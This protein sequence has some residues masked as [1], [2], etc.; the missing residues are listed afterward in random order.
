MT[1]S[2]IIPVYNVAPYLRECLDSVCVAADRAGNREGGTGN[3]CGVE[4]ICV[5]DGS[6]DGN[7]EMLDE[8]ARRSTPTPSTH[9]FKVIHQPNVGVSAAR[10]RGLEI[11]TWEWVWFVDADDEIAEDSLKLL[12]GFIDD[13]RYAPLQWVSFRHDIIGESRVKPLKCDGVLYSKTADCRIAKTFF[14]VAWSRIFR[15]STIGSL[16]FRAYHYNEDA[17]FAMDFGSRGRGWLGVDA[18]LY[19]YRLSAGGGDVEKTVQGGRRK[20]L[21]ERE[22]PDRLR[23]P[24]RRKIP[25][26]GSVGVAS[27]SGYAQFPDVREGLFQAERGRTRRIAP[28]LAVPSGQVFGML[29]VLLQKK[30]LPLIGAAFP[31][32][33]GRQISCDRPRTGQWDLQTPLPEECV[34]N[35]LYICQNNLRDTSFG[36]VQ[37]THFISKA[38]K[39]CGTV[40]AFC[41]L[42]GKVTAVEDAALKYVIAGKVAPADCVCHWSA[43]PGVEIFG[44]VEDLDSLYEESLA[45]V[46]PVFSGSGT[47]IKV[48]ETGLRGRTVFAAPFAARGMAADAPFLKV[49]DTV[50]L[51]RRDLLAFL[52]RVQT[53]GEGRCPAAGDPARIRKDFEAEVSRGVH[54]I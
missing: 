24:R 39:S 43:V 17:V 38:L 35:I 8:Y 7:G 13:P 52:D 36:G 34:V 51:M 16:R 20:N 9:T 44:F 42:G 23:I 4:I 53:S 49:S 11:A 12:K 50:E 15:R 33:T 1:F 28:R 30:D 26:S 19:H 47:C 14:G 27:G 31:F 32:G 22:R 10:N 3:G 18:P 37:R 48:Q 46:A 21:R 6:T 45:V 2:I 41:P 40:Y 5:D 54:G 29:Q 25:R